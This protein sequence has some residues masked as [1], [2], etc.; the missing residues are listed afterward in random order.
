MFESYIRTLKVVVSIVVA[1]FLTI[2]VIMGVFETVGASAEAS[3]GFIDQMV[4]IIAAAIRGGLSGGIEGAMQ[5]LVITTI[6][7]AIIDYKGQLS[8]Q[9]AGKW[10]VEKLPKDKFPREAKGEKGRIPLSN[11]VAEIVLGVCFT[12]LS[13]MVC[14]DRISI[15]YSVQ[16]SQVIPLPVSTF[17]N[18]SFLPLCIMVFIMIGVL[19]VAEGVVKILYRRFSVPVCLTVIGCNLFELAGIWFLLTRPAI[20][21]AT[22]PEML[23]PILKW[24]EFDLLRF[25]ANGEYNPLLMMIGV[26]CTIAFIIGS[27]ITVVKTVQ[28]TA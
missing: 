5:A 1:V 7:F 6:V 26:A 28:F 3:E 17:L 9:K 8:H 22:V 10:T 12:I 25:V 27:V 21:Q 24:G 4:N 18:S 15:I 14:T 13:V 11:G 23:K 19:S 2:G 20:F 16:E